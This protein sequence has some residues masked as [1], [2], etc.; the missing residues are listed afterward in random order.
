MKLNVISIVMELLVLSNSTGY[1]QKRQEEPRRQ[2]GAYETSFVDAAEKASI[3]FVKQ[4]TVT[5]EALDIHHS[6]MLWDG[7]NDLPWAMRTAADSS[8]DKVD[9]SR[10]TEFHTDID[11]LRKG[12]VKAQFWSVFVP[13]STMADGNAFITTIEQIDLVH[14]MCERYPDVFEIALTADDVERIV[15]LGKIASLI[16]VEGGHSI[17]NSLGRLQELY[18]RGARYMTL[19]HSRNLDWADACTDVPRVG[20]LNAFGEEVVREMNRM[21]MLVD[22]SHVSAECMRKTLAVTRA[23]VIFSHSSAL[24]ICDHPR[25]VPDD[26]LKLTAKNGGIVMVNFSTGF[27]LPK[28]VTDARREALGDLRIIVDHIDHIVNIAG[29]DHVGMG[30]DY[31]G[32]PRLPRGAE[33]VST[34]PALTQELL[35]RGYDREQIH[36]ILG[37]NMLRVLR[38]TEA[39]AR[40]IQNEK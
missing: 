21:G 3:E 40:E 4:F 33:D 5:E 7:H 34:Y 1:A 26:V 8:F 35:N 24:A 31:D 18:N 10:P 22:I 15:A 12:G 38:K 23:P 32:I 39:V 11:R 17:E 19:T 30:S 27:V 37:G 9:I 25:N 6:G 29:I 13:V 2:P 28:S 20:G 16:G 36:K 14:K